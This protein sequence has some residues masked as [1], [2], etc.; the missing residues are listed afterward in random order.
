[1]I[2]V[3]DERKFYIEQFVLSEDDN[4]LKWDESL[5]QAKGAI[6]IGYLFSAKEAK[7]YGE[8]VTLNLYLVNK[9]YAMNVVS[10]TLKDLQIGY[11][12]LYAEDLRFVFHNPPIDYWINTKENWCKKLATKMSEKYR[13]TYDEALSEVYFAIAEIAQKPNVYLGNLGYI[14]STV[15]NNFLGNMRFNR[16]RLSGDTP[17]ILYLDEELDT[18]DGLSTAHDF[19]GNEDPDMNALINGGFGE[20]ALTELKRSFS[21]REVDMILE[22]SSSMLPKSIY[23]RIWAW[24]KKN[25]QDELRRRYE[26]GSS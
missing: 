20:Y 16:K 9:R 23:K 21:K 10:L 19:I 22:W 14:Q 26:N 2:R 7:L 8:V 25:S 18:D 1:V 11:L 5:A 6:I 4:P 15:N 13:V 24:R 3:K 17:G 12:K